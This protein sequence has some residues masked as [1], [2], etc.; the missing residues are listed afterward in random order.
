[1]TDYTSENIN[2]IALALSKAQAQIGSAKKDT[3]GYG[4]NYAKLENVQ[5]AVKAPFLTNELSYTH[6]L[7]GDT[8]RCLLMHSSGQWIASDYSFQAEVT[9][10]VNINQAKG[11]CIT[12]GR[13]YTLAGIAGVPQEDDDGVSSGPKNIPMNTP[14]EPKIEAYLFDVS[15]STT[16]GGLSKVHNKHIKELKEIH[17]KDKAK[18]NEVTLAYAEKLSELQVQLGETLIKQVDDCKDGVLLNSLIADKEFFKRFEYLKEN[19]KSAHGVVSSA[20]DEFNKGNNN[21]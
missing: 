4:Y 14:I 16:I 3:K 18:H 21:D 15:G 19:N 2:D 11:S 12:Y 13:R 7:M 8:V 6:I 10:N 9:K 20:I 17:S 5:D 1:M